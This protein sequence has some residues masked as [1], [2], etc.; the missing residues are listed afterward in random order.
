[1]DWASMAPADG[2]WR[3]E[4]RDEET[5][6]RSNDFYVTKAD[7]KILKRIESLALADTQHE[8]LLIER[9]TG[10]SGTGLTDNFD[11]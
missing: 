1:M 2:S 5:W 10:N 8:S 6:K 4:G 3:D 7:R 9:S 11:F